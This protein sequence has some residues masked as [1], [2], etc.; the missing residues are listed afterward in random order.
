VEYLLHVLV[1]MA[2]YA[3]A[4]ASFN[5][6]IGYGGLFSLAQAG[7]FGVGAYASALLTLRLGWPPLLAAVAGM[8][9]AALVS[10]VVALPSL[11]VSGDYLVVT[12]FG[13]QVLLGSIF[14]NWTAV[15]RGPMGVPGIPA[16]SA[17]GLEA[18]G[19]AGNLVVAAGALLVTV[20][21][22]ARIVRSPFG[23]VLRALREDEVVT[24][25]LGKNVYR[26]KV[27]A[28]V[29]AGMLAALGGSVYAHYV[30]FIDPGSFTLD[31]S[32]FML[33][34]VIVGGTATL[35][36]PLIGSVILVG[37]PE[38]L[39]FLGLPESIAASLRQMFFGALLVVFMRLRPQGLVSEGL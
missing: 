14:L 27:L 8:A 34:I 31:E 12:S 7:L 35:S 6:L 4:G 32:V 1:F 2:I 25:A 11:R 22:L 30:S 10:A 20:C 24:S 36:G 29:V 26:F 37:L 16:A 9:I 23:R 3:I 38:L 39:R 13:I 21:V 15:T 5:L 28:F 17:F 18:R 19:N 33:S